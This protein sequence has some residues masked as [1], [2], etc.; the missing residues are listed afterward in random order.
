[1]KEKLAKI[2]NVILYVYSTFMFLMAI[3]ELVERENSAPAIVLVVLLCPGFYWLLHKKWGE[4]KRIPVWIFRGVTLALAPFAIGCVILACPNH[5]CFDFSV[6]RQAKE[7]FEAENNMEV[8]EYKEVTS[9]QKPL[10]ADYRTVTALV[11]YADRQTG[12]EMQQEV[13]MYFDCVEAL[14]FDTFEEMRQY[15]RMHASEQFV[16][17]C[18]FEE[19]ALDARMD[20]VI[21]YVVDDQYEEIQSVLTESCRNDV[22]ES[23]WEEWQQK[24]SS[25]GS[26]QKIKDMSWNYDVAEDEFNSQTFSVTIVVGFIDGVA[27]LEMVIN[28]EM[29]LERLEVAK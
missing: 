29:M 16:A 14:W 17:M 27:N 22:T 13:H 28:E 9:I 21:G 26:Y 18:H 23:K 11:K 8:L 15:R 19:A 10:T 12:Q 1:M 20:E 6:E 4:T 3:D 2:G 24:L 25:L 5:R 7:H